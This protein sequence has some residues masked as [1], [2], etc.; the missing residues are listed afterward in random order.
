MHRPCKR[1]LAVC[2]ALM[3]GAG[4]QTKLTAPH[5]NSAVWLDRSLFMNH[6]PHCG[7][8]TSCWRC[9]PS[10]LTGF[11]ATMERHEWLKEVQQR[12]CCGTWPWISRPGCPST[13]SHPPISKPRF[14]IFLLRSWRHSHWKDRLKQGTEDKE[15]ETQPTKEGEGD[16]E[17]KVLANR[18]GGFRV[19]L[20]LGPEVSDPYLQ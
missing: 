16:N 10:A 1:S 20:E 5:Q 18:D 2:F 11:T 3:Q 8:S 14:L 15:R 9:I 4:C 12:A 19:S 7:W 6:I 13:T 17:N